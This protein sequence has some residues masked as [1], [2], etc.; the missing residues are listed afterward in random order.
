MV[1]LS[2]VD[3]ILLDGKE[4]KCLLN[5]SNKYHFIAKLSFYCEQRP[6]WRY[7]PKIW[8]SPSSLPPCSGPCIEVLGIRIRRISMFFGASRNRIH[9]SE[10]RIRILPFGLF[11]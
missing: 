4:K 1:Q 6:I 3:L 7:T 5:I 2:Q 8:S 9:K 10:V 11:S